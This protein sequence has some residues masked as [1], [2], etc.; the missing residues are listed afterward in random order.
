MAH[1][2][3]AARGVGDGVDA[4]QDGDYVVAMFEGGDEMVAFIGVVSEPVEQ[5]GEAPFRRVGTAAPLD[6]ERGRI[7]GPFR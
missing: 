7:H 3:D 1:G 6:G 2:A 4:A 5:L